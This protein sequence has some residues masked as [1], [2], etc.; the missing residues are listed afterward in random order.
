MSVAKALKD[1]VILQVHH[2]SDKPQ[3][4]D[5]RYHANAHQ[6]ILVLHQ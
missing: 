2:H 5:E 4:Y 1:F 6:D 3:Q